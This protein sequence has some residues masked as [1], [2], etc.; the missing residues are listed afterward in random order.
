MQ[1]LRLEAVEFII[2]SMQDLLEGNLPYDLWNVGKRIEYMQYTV[3][4][5]TPR[6]H[7]RSRMCKEFRDE[8]MSAQHMGILM[9]VRNE[10]GKSRK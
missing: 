9:E 10:F 2:Q 6:E 4:V 7:R 1:I 3:T 8:F 5:E